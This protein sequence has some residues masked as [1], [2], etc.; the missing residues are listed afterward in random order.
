[1]VQH[2]NRAKGKNR[3]ANKKENTRGLMATGLPSSVG[4]RKPYVFKLL[5]KRALTTKQVRAQKRKPIKFFGEVF[6]ATFY[7][8]WGGAFTIS[9]WAI[10]SGYSD[11]NASDFL[12]STSNSTATYPDTANY[13][14]AGHTLVKPGVSAP[15]TELGLYRA[16][17]SSNTTH[18]VLKGRPDIEKILTATNKAVVVEIEEIK[19]SG[20]DKG[21]IDS[22]VAKKT[23]YIKIAGNSGSLPDR[24]IDA[25]TGSY[26]DKVI[27][28]LTGSNGTTTVP[29]NM[30][31]SGGHKTFKLVFREL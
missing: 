24:F 16:N 6:Y 14:V 15:G 21:N 23:E 3:I 12:D 30:A 25:T 2:G 17:G 11:R 10:V 27:F 13:N 5:R 18:L 19:S 4:S 1:M 20:T 8:N 7:N 26:E 9:Y 29:T 31:S 22:A 28:N